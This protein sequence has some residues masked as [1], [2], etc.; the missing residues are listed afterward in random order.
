MRSGEVLTSI[1][2]DITTPFLQEEEGR[3]D[4]VYTGGSSQVP[5]VPSFG[6]TSMLYQN[7]SQGAG[8]GYQP[9]LAVLFLATCSTRIN[10]WEPGILKVENWGKMRYESEQRCQHPTNQ[11]DDIE[12]V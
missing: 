8:P 9:S 7:T 4:R 5:S 12:P 11:A 10:P 2:C 6:V 1:P 3:D